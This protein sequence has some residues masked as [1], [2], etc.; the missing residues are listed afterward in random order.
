MMVKIK[1]VGM[2][3][4][5]V[6]ISAF[7]NYYEN[8][9]WEIDSDSKIGEVNSSPEEFKNTDAEL[10]KDIA[11]Q[12]EDEVSDDEWDE[13]IDEE[14]EDD[15]IEKPLSEMNHKELVEKAISVGIKSDNMN[16]KQLREA[17]RKASK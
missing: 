2:S 1:K 4:R 11:E 8:S 10:D 14:V 13:A 12:P 15:E 16:N 5:M 9:G 17:I 6:T 3:P 7:H